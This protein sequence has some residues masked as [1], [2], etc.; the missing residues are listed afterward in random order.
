MKHY[1]KISHYTNDILDELPSIE[2]DIYDLVIDDEIISENE[3]CH[4]L[5][6][7]YEEEPIIE[8]LNKFVESNILQSIEIN[9]SIIDKIIKLQSII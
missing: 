2:Y 8:C 7:K 4:N 1:I 6:D 5:Y 9:K 3:I